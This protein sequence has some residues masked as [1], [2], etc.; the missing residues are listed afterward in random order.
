MAKRKKHLW[1][2][3]YCPSDRDPVIGLTCRTLE[4]AKFSQ[5]VNKRADSDWHKEMAIYRQ[6]PIGQ[7][8]MR[9]QARLDLVRGFQL[10]PEGVTTLVDLRM[11]LGSNVEEATVEA[12]Y[13]IAGCLYTS[14]RNHFL[15]PL[16]VSPPKRCMM[17]AGRLMRPELVD[18]AEP[19]TK[20]KLA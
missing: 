9:I 12:C 7:E 13:Q 18:V 15:P 6:N 10:G 4:L 5:A 17:L 2:L 3:V 20:R 16:E 19:A 1:E 11:F 8:L 14:S